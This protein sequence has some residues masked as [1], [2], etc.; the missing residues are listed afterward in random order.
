MNLFKNQTLAL[1]LLCPLSIFLFPFVMGFLRGECNGLT[2]PDL[3]PPVLSILSGRHLL[4]VSITPRALIQVTTDLH[5][6]KPGVQLPVLILLGPLAAL[7]TT[8]C[9]F[10]TGPPQPRAFMASLLPLC[11][12]YLLSL[13]CKRWRL[14]RLI[15]WTPS[16]FCLCSLPGALAQLLACLRTSHSPKCLSAQT[17]LQ[18]TQSLCV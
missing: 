6:T 18:P 9:F 16:P 2:L 7:G 1:A 13:T 14:P 11:C 4:L 15:S 12:F 8:D 3:S 5:V 10:P 17:F